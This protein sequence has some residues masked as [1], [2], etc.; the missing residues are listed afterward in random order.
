MPANQGGNDTFDV[1]STSAATTSA[2]GN[3]NDTLNVSSTVASG[4]T[5]SN[6]PLT[7][8]GGSGDTSINVSDDGSGDTIVMANEPI[9]AGQ[10]VA[11]V[12]GA[13]LQL[14]YS[15]PLAAAPDV[16]FTLNMGS[17][18]NN[19]AYVLGTQFPTTIQAGSGTNT[20]DLGGVPP[21][22]GLDDNGPVAGAT[23]ATTFP[24]TLTLSGALGA[25]LTNPSSGGL[26]L[27]VPPNETLAGFNQAITIEG[28]AGTTLSVDDA[29]D[30]QF[31][32][33]ILSA[34]SIVGIGE[35]EPQPGQPTIQFAGI[36]AMNLA[37]GSGGSQL[38]VQSTF[39]SNGPITINTG[40]GTATALVESS[41]APLVFDGTASTVNE[42]TIT[43]DATSD[44]A[45]MLAATLQDGSAPYSGDAQLTGFGPIDTVDFAG[46]QQANLNLGQ[47]LNCADDQS[48]RAQ[49]DGEHRSE[50]DQ[51]EQR[52][53]G[54]RFAQRGRQYDHHRPDRCLH[55]GRCRRSNQR[56]EWPEHRPGRDPGARR[57]IR[58]SAESH[59]ASST[60]R[61]SGSRTWPT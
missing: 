20:V 27:Q 36:G 4:A 26:T 43:F 50:G 57:R 32:Y 60:S 44:N 35:P 39:A 1:T 21:A 7:F 15:I 14:Q 40:S 5:V 46:F 48:R 24:A 19:T 55:P 51:P 54:R 52:H 37:L 10:A 23:P 58:P 45:A 13:G 49:P 42:N 41:S 18:G 33:P 47:N 17:G 34:G 3:G 53:P 6:A 31:R 30:S 8:V 59:R 28:G 25:T 22:I 11:A 9:Q 56:G 2:G 29:G 61:S 38:E 12:V 16:I